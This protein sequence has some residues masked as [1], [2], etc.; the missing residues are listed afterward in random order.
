[1]NELVIKN[2]R[3][4]FPSLFKPSA[5]DAGAQPKYSATL[6]LDKKE[7]AAAI[8][9]LRQ[10]VS[11][12][13]TEQWNK[14]PKKVFYSLQ[15]GDTLDRAEYEGKY[16]IKATNRKRVPIIDK[17]LTALVEEDERPY[18]GCYVNAK[19]RF[20]A[21]SNGASFSGVLC[22]LEAVQFAKDGDSFGS[23]GNALDGFDAIQSETA[24][25]VA[26]EAEEFL[27]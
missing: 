19:I 21:W 3:L 9:T 2:A 5:F 11:A 4:S 12:L 24:E 15:D 23:G 1:M 22:S 27:A 25:D 14:L 8:A 16:I 10:L 20:Y 26:E 18:A 17:D 7:D 6:I 13:A